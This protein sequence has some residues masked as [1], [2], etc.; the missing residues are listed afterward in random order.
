MASLAFASLLIAASSVC[1][2]DSLW[3]VI[4]SLVS[5]SGGL[6]LY[7]IFYKICFNISID[8]YFIIFHDDFNS[9]V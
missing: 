1:P 9:I 2:L 6:I 3:S 4:S 7:K 8:F 5:S